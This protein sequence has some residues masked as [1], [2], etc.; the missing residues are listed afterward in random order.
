MRR[1]RFLTPRVEQ[2]LE[3]VG[4]AAYIL[5][6][7]VILGGQYVVNLAGTAAS[8]PSPS[9]SV[10]A[11]PTPQV[12]TATAASAATPS[13]AP[14]PTR[15]PLVVTSYVSG[16]HHFAALSA[17]VGYTLMSPITGT[18]SVVV[19]QFLG[20]DI[21]VGSNVPSEPFYPYVTITSADVKLILRPGAL[22]DD[23]QLLVKDRDTIRAG[24]P[25]LTIVG[26]GASSWRTFYDRS[27]T[28]QVLASVTA[29]TSGAELDPLALFAR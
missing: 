7:V 20:G 22:K 17:P 2:I 23:V 14:S 21:R 27:F 5:A 6:A 11:S 25:L 24:A 8:A 12:T 4:F 29:R 19:Y 13:A 28:A 18:V 1:P 26:N 3:R 10:T 15:D 16:G 9:G